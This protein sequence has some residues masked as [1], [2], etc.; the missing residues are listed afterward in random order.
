MWRQPVSYPV[1]C[2]DKDLFAD[3]HGHTP[4]MPR[5]KR[6]VPTISP[7]ADVSDRSVQQISWL[8]AHFCPIVTLV[9]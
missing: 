3:M 4:D 2:P 8:A 6:M 1:L 5:R 7:P 9:S